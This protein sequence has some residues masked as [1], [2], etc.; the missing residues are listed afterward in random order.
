MRGMQKGAIVVAIV[1]TL[2]SS[3][4]HADNKQAAKEAYTEGK[5]NYD[6]G[7]YDAAL[8]AFKKAYLNYE[9]PVFLFNIAQC[10]RQLGDR[11]NAVRTYRVFLQ[12]WPKAPNR[13]RVEEIIAELESAIAQDLAAKNAPPKETMPPGKPEPAH[14]EAAPR[15]TAPPAATSETTTPKPAPLAS[16][17]RPPE[18]TP[19]STTEPAKP[20]GSKLAPRPPSHADYTEMV[21]VTPN[22]ERP[23]GSGIKVYK[24]WWFWTVLGVVVAGVAATAIA[25][26]LTQTGATFK[27][28]L[29]DYTAAGLRVSF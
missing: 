24:K 4:A 11:Q 2:A 29:P 28:T 13:G 3:A 16:S 8:A 27:P 14:V 17:T 1:C 25:L 9:E 26:P 6:L 23:S 5:R 10:Y 22:F 15:P 18:A 21:E 12:N 20:A 19:P 7:E